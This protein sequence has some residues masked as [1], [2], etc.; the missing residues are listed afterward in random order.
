M[1]QITCQ[2]ICNAVVVSECSETGDW[3][4]PRCLH[5]PAMVM[6]E[7]WTSLSCCIRSAAEKCFEVSYCPSCATLFHPGQNSGS[8]VYL[9]VSSAQ[10]KGGDSLRHYSNQTLR[11]VRD[12]Q[13]FQ[14]AGDQKDEMVAHSRRPGYSP[15]SFALWGLNRF[16]LMSLPCFSQIWNQDFL[17]L[18]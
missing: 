13:N 5:F 15:F 3:G 14:R 10:G 6:G 11:K 8:V 17:S 16:R 18:A 2:T 4:F 12:M 1:H 9:H 7:L